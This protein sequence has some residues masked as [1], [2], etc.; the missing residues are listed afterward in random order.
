M[1]V[2]MKRLFIILSVVLM[3]YACEAPTEY[4]VDTEL[5]DSLQAENDSLRVVINSLEVAIDTSNE[6]SYLKYDLQLQVAAFNTGDVGWNAVLVGTLKNIGEETIRNV[7]IE[8]KITD[9]VTGNV[10]SAIGYFTL[11][12]VD[13]AYFSEYPYT[14]EVN[15]APNTKYFFYVATEDIYVSTNIITWSV[16]PIVSLED[17]LRAE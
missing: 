6:S 16:S 3:G 4:V 7:G 2:K 13:W 11:E 5:T 15:L 1:E 12:K 10:I 9:S 14:K 8:L 17:N